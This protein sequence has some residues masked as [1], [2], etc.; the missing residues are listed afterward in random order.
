VSSPLPSRSSDLTPLPGVPAGTRAGAVA[1]P[2]PGSAAERVTELRERMNG[3]QRDRWEPRGRQLTGGL[4]ELLPNGLLRSGVVYTVDNSTS[5]IM[6]LLGSA[7]ADGAWAAVV[8]LPDL[9]VEAAAGFGIALD[10]LVLVP[11][12]GDQW[13]TVTAALVDVLP[14]VVVHPERGVGGADIARLGAR[15]RQTGCTLLVA[16]AW[17]QSEASFSV[18][19]TAW[20]GVASG[21]GYL[22]GRDLTVEVAER[23]GPRRFETIHLPDPAGTGDRSPA[24]RAE[25]ARARLEQMRQRTRRHP[26]AG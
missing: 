16:G 14:L 24:A 23:A 21:H 5:L 8:G 13:L 4:A 19:G 1:G 6:A 2:V 17:A 3:M 9:G 12:P 22:S 25:P 10:R 15:L 26:V 20:A 7:T 18:T 11:Q